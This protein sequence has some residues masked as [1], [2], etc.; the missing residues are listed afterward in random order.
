MEVIYWA[1]CIVPQH[2]TLCNNSASRLGIPA[3]WKFQ[4]QV[5]MAEGLTR[6]VGLA[7]VAGQRTLGDW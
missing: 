2:I 3:S 7:L 6:A 1:L 4:R 5:F